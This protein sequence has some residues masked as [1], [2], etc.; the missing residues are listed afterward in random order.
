VKSIAAI[1]LRCLLA[2]ALVTGGLSAWSM[3]DAPMALDSS[4]QTTSSASDGQD[5]GCH[6]AGSETAADSA[7][8][9]SPADCCNEPEGDC[10]HE[11]CDCV[12]PGLTIVVPAGI[13]AAILANPQGLAFAFATAAPQKVTTT[14]LRPPRA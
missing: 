13:A 8:E 9:K 7:S 5:A 11:K 12:C 1:A 6:P 4:S 10:T 2:T 14:L 3:S